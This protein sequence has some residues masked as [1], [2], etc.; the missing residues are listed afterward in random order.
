M[1][2]KVYRYIIHL[3]HLEMWLESFFFINTKL[4][5]VFY[6]YGY[7]LYIILKES[8]SVNHIIFLDY[9]TGMKI[10]VSENFNFQ[11]SKNYLCIRCFG[12]RLKID[13]DLHKHII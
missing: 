11:Y 1:Y 9:L 10:V 6:R 12:I 4:I 3:Y 2:K 8:K 7:H 13:T 5:C